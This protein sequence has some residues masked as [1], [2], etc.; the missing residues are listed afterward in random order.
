MSAFGFKDRAETTNSL[1]PTGWKNYD[2]SSP[3]QWGYI[4]TTL[5]PAD[6]GTR[7]AFVQLSIWDDCW[8]RGPLF[9]HEGEEES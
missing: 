2:A 3:N 7:G 5:N 4:P 9:L 1:S 6:K 8:L